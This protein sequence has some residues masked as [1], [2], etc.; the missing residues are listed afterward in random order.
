M[1]G[2]AFE[3]M[4]LSSTPKS[5]N[6]AEILPRPNSLPILFAWN[7]G[8]SGVPLIFIWCSSLPSPN[9]EN[10]KVQMNETDKLNHAKELFEIRKIRNSQI[11]IS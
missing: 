5:F 11:I 4:H 2:P 9:G 1:R 10:K 7:K 8:S 3:I 6:A